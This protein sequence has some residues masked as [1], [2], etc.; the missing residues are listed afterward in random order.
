MVK[1][2]LLR[3]LMVFVMAGLVLANTEKTIFVAIDHAPNQKHHDNRP[4]V[5]PNIPLRVHLD[6]EDWT[7]Q[8][9]AELWYTL[10]TTPGTRYEVRVCWPATTPTDFH[11][12]LSN[13]EALRIQA[14]PSYRSYLPTYSLSPPPLDFDIILDPFLWGMIPRSLLGTL[15]W[16]VAVVGVSVWVSVRVVWRLL[17]SVVR[18][19]EKVE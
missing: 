10:D 2:I 4:V 12:S 1:M 3:L 19:R 14:I 9:G 7:V 17:K 18:E 8:D 6:R 15:G 11:F 16:V 13:N 5:K